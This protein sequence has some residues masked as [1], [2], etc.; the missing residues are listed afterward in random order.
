M[1]PFSAQ[2]AS[3]RLRVGGNRSPGVREG[4]ERPLG[5]PEA[6]ERARIGG[7]RPGDRGERPTIPLQRGEEPGRGAQGPNTI[8]QRGKV[9]VRGRRPPHTTTK[10]RP[11]AGR[12]PGGQGGWPRPR[13]RAAQPSG[14]V[15]G[16]KPRGRGFETQHVQSHPKRSLWSFGPLRTPICMIFRGEDDGNIV[17]ASTVRFHARFLVFIPPCVYLGVFR[18]IFPPLHVFASFPSLAMLHTRA[19]KVVEARGR[20]PRPGLGLGEPRKAS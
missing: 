15:A 7:E 13:K 9:V 4:R 19:H 17:D 14:Q 8:T 10:G 12:Y 16:P 20:V 1:G 6:R 2:R 3:Q 18:L 5:R 11:W